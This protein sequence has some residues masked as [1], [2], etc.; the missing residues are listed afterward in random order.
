MC[1]YEE[2]CATFLRN[3]TWSFDEEKNIVS[4]TLEN[5]IC[6]IVDLN[7]NAVHIETKSDSP[8]ELETFLVKNK[9]LLL[10]AASAY[11]SGYAYGALTYCK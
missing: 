10:F 8:K 3:P 6:V 9:A 11:W 1:N 7:H 5:S 2:N 4:I